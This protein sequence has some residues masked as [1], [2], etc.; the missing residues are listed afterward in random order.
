MTPKTNNKN[1]A[2]KNKNS[3]LIQ[4]FDSSSPDER[5]SSNKEIHL[6]FGNKNSKT[7]NRSDLLSKESY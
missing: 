1:D 2:R 4:T 6:S 3:E 7:K 5:D